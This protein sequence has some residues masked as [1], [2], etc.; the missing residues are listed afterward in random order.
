MP[1]NIQPIWVFKGRCKGGIL[2]I[3]DG[4][5]KLLNANRNDDA[6]WLS[7]GYGFPDSEWGRGY[8]FAFVVRQVSGS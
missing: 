6:S 4:D 8:G 5:P 2:H 7:T 1:N 3:S